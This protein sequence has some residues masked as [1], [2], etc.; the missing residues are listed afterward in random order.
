MVGLWSTESLRRD[1]DSDEHVAARASALGDLVDT[2][3]GHSYGTAILSTKDAAFHST[4]DI[5]H[6]T[7]LV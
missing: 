7:P 2:E 4:C 5:C 1:T 6:S 3:E